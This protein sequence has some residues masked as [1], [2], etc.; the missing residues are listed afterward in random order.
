LRIRSQYRTFDRVANRYERLVSGSLDYRPVTLMIVVAL[1]GVT[2]YMFFKTSSK[3]AP[4]E[5]SGA[6]FSLTQAP[7]YAT[8]EYTSFYAD[9]IRELTK[10]IPELRANFSIVGMGGETNSG[11]AVWAFKDWAERERSQAE[12]QPYRAGLRMLR[13]RR[14][15]YLRHRHC[16]APAAACRS[17]W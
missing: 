4:E 7:R 10:D 12:I 8:S 11:F 3:L 6:L 15:W 9:R 17:R 16:P 14:R 5:D 13:A 1:M 2:G